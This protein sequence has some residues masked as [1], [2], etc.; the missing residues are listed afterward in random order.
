MVSVQRYLLNAMIARDS[1]DFQPVTDCMNTDRDAL[2]SSLDTIESINKDYAEDVISIRQKLESVAVYNAQIMD[3]ASNLGNED[4]IDLAY[5]V[6]LNY[7]APAFDEAADMIVA[8]K[9]RIDQDVVAQGTMVKS[10]QAT[11]RAIVIII[12]VLSLGAVGFFTARMLR[13]IMVPIRGLL[14]ALEALAQGNFE[15]ASIHYDSRDEFGEFAA[16]ITNVVKR[17]IFITQDLEEGLKSIADGQYNAHSQDD[18]QYE[19]EFHVLRDSVYHL[20]HML[21][22]IMCQIQTTSNEVSSGAQQVANG[23][24]ALSQGATEQA[25]SIQE[26][27]ATLGDVSHQVDENTSLISQVEK[28]VNETVSEES[29]LSRHRRLPQTLWHKTRPSSRPPWEWI[30]FPL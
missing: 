24:Q 6:Y 9:D 4:S 25:S 15:N 17:I 14:V 5:N 22:D 8:L 26:L 16:K 13:Y 1:S 20:I 3:L 27:A 18:S 10:A 23:A 7:Y 28:S 11:S 30:R 29:S 2:Y 19:G 21:N 12:F